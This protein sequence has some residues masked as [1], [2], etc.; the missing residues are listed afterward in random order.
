[1][2]RLYVLAALATLS[3]PV[4]APQQFAP[5]LTAPRWVPVLL[6][7][8][9]FLSACFL[10]A[11]YPRND[12]A[13]CVTFGLVFFLVRLV[14]CF[15]ASLADPDANVLWT[16]VSSPWREA[17]G[18]TLTYMYSTWW[19]AGAQYLALL[20]WMPAVLEAVM[21][22][23]FRPRSVRAASARPPE[24][25]LPPSA[26]APP[27]QE[28]QTLRDLESELAG[29]PGLVGWMVFSPDRLPVWRFGEGAS[30]LETAPEVMHRLG[31]VCQTVFGPEWGR[32]LYQGMFRTDSGYC[33]LI[34]LPGD[35]LFGSLWRVEDGQEPGKAVLQE[36]LELMER[37]VQYRFVEPS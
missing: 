25:A 19:I 28:P 7:G 2:I 9:V 15:G 27:P 3:V 33:F 31:D 17:L 23:L 24:T 34:I 1:M 20:L 5:L 21:P 29:Y 16:S 14:L 6:L 30:V 18:L 4:L 12:F 22:G 11:F 32:T 35:F 13:R 26:P 37:W 10:K 8:E 36:V